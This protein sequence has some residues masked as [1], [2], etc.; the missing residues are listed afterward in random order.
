MSIVTTSGS[1]KEIHR[2]LAVARR[3]HELQAR[4]L[5]RALDLATHDVRVV[6]D[7]QFQGCGSVHSRA[8]G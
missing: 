5:V 1:A 7:H 2:L 4:A 3:A 8:P 6:D